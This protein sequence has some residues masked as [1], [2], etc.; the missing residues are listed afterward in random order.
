[1]S[2][3]GLMAI[4]E[5]TRREARAAA[6]ATTAPPTCPNDGELL[7]PDGDGDWRCPFDGWSLRE[8]RVP[9]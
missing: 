5:T 7:V 4:I 6:S 2:W 9:C 8:R 1:M 3:Y